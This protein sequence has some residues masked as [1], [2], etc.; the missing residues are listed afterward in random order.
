ML[1]H[2][3]VTKQSSKALFSKSDFTP[4]RQLYYSKLDLPSRLTIIV[5]ANGSGKTSVVEVF[6][7]LNYILEWARGRVVNPFHKWWGYGNVVWRHSEDLPIT[8]GFKMRLESLREK[9]SKIL[10]P[11]IA[12][13]LQTDIILQRFGIDTITAEITYEFDVTGRGGKFQVQREHYDY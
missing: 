7:L 9:V 1:T 13:Y 12:D 8:I 5:G 4:A 3:V 2:K 6:E 10:D 11:E